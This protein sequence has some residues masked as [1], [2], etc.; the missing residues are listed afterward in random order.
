MNNSMKITNVTEPS[1]AVLA[2]HR[3][4]CR[5]V[6]GLLCAALGGNSGGRPAGA[7]WRLAGHEARAE[8]PE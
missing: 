2:R 7:S 1:A 4:D 6:A 3:L 5:L 8:M